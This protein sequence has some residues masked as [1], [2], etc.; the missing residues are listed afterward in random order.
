MSSGS[1]SVGPTEA[2]EPPGGQTEP[3]ARQATAAAAVTAT[4]E[5]DSA[6][7]PTLRHRSVALRQRYRRSH[8][9]ADIDASVHFARQAVAAAFNKP[10]LPGALADLANALRVRFVGVG[11]TSDTDDID[12]AVEV[13][14]RAVAVAAELRSERPW[15]WS[16]LTLTYRTR[17][18]SL[19]NLPD[20]DRAVEAAQ[21]GVDL[22]AA[23]PHGGRLAALATNLRLRYTRTGH[24]A[25]ANR[26]VRNAQRA[27]TATH[28]V[29]PP[30]A[31]RLSVLAAA[32]GARYSGTHQLDDI[33]KSIDALREPSRSPTR[34]RAPGRTGGRTWAPPYASAQNAPRPPPT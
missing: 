12:E 34:T 25:D 9:Q 33:D 16:T 23:N 28:D 24:V 4:V 31:S 19:Q 11:N 3:P 30:R 22:E 2:P 15:L 17:Y 20:L 10:E 13:A 14:E 26:S 29:G 18:L 7:P 1:A 8:H 5:A 6:A 27:V 21:R 32:R